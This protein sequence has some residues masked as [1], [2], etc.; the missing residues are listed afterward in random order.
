MQ[1]GNDKENI[2]ISV[3]IVARNSAAVLFKCLKALSENDE[4]TKPENSQ[5]IIV[6][7]ASTDGSI[8]IACESYPN[9]SVIK[10]SENMGFAFA[11]N[12]GIRLAENE[13]ILLLN[14]DAIIMNGSIDTLRKALLLLDKNAVAGPRLMR[15]NGTIQKSVYPEPTMFTELFKPIVKFIVSF[16]EVLYKSDK[17]YRVSSLRGACFLAKKSALVNVGLFDERYFFY[18]EETD[19]FR[20]LKKKGFYITYVPSSKVVHLGGRGSD[21]IDFNK[22][23]MYKTSLL[24]Y[25]KKNRS[26]VETIIITFYLKFN[27]GFNKK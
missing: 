21:T 2:K 27:K 26:W 24:K 13:L 16:K 18:L 23:Q 6:D 15:L 17:V 22:A 5:W 19:L 14:T 1:N 9:I 3:V 25:F 4:A 10:N 12:Q 20:Q 7:N 8:D 11:S